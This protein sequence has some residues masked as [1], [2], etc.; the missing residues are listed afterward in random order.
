MTRYSFRDDYSEGAHPDILQALQATNLTQYQGYGNDPCSEKAKALIKQKMDNQDVDI[1][2]L[3]GG[4]Q[5][6]LVVISSLL[7]PHE[8]VISAESGHI[9]QHE[10]GAIEASGH[11]INSIYCED[12]KLTPERIEKVLDKNETEH[13]VKPKLVFLSNATEIGTVYTKNDLQKLKNFCESKDLLLYLDGARLGSALCSKQSNLDLS[14]LGK[15]VDIFYI[16]GTKN[17]ALLGEALVICKEELKPDFRY[18]LKQKGALLAKGR[19]LGGQFQELFKDNLY[20]ELAGHANQMAAKLREGIKKAGYDF[21]SESTTNQIF[22]VLPEDK[23]EKLLKNYDFYVWQKLAGEMSAIRLI[24]S[25]ATREAAVD[26]FLK[27]L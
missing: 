14:E 15:L 11:K 24:T 10:A 2:F 9:N 17:G 20:F 7:R 23:I 4:T 8:S 27:E 16:G 19:V 1:H 21:L 26:S 5:V 18:F 3:S 13:M 25:W 12:G 22:P 6:N